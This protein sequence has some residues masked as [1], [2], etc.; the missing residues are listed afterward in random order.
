MVTVT[1]WAKLWRELV[2]GREQAS[3]L[4]EGGSGD[5]DRV[6]RRKAGEFD[7]HVKEQAQRPDPIRDFILARVTPD[8]SVLDIGAGT[9]KWVTALAGRV[10]HITAMD[11]S[12][13]MLARLRDNVA[14]EGIT[15]AEVIQGAW[16][17]VEVPPHDISLCSHAVYAV[18]DL[19][20]FVRAMAA[21]T[22][23][24]CYMILKSPLRSGILA[25]A[26]NRIWGHPHD[27][28]NFAV[29]Y[30]VLLDMGY[31]PNV[32]AEP[33]PWDPWRHDS[34]EE[35]LADSK[36]RL[37]ISHTTEH[38]RY[39]MGLLER[40]LTLHDGQYVWPKGVR[41]VLVYWDPAEQI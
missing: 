25:E 13:A 16:P 1:D 11:P 8:M 35:A 14:R 28:P 30:N 31:C 15:N 20:S 40:E 21:A 9:G 32:L 38:N 41:S 3:L 37:R 2:V 7:R 6:W 19:P 10:R 17:G 34:L 36:R 33:V 22:L 26:S 29:A 4:L 27:G 24:C 12:P 5:E 18:E 23:R 39:L